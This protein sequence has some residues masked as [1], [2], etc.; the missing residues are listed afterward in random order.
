[1][2]FRRSRRRPELYLHIGQPKSG[3][4]SLQDFLAQERSRLQ[5]QGFLYPRLRHVD[6]DNAQHA[7]SYELREKTVKG[8][9]MTPHDVSRDAGVWEQLTHQVK[10]T[11]CRR[12][13]LS[14]ED[15]YFLDQ[16]SRL[17]RSALAVLADRL[18]PMFDSI[19]VVA[20]LRR[21]D[22]HVESWCNELIK[23]GFNQSTRDIA[24]LADTLPACHSDYRALRKSWVRR[25]GEQAVIFKPFQR[26]RLKN[27]SVVD[28][29]C[30]F[31]GYQPSEMLSGFEDRNPRLTRL[32]FEI[33]RHLN[34]F[35]H[36]L[37][38]HQRAVH[39]IRESAGESRHDPGAGEPYQYFNAPLRD[40]WRSSNQALPMN[41]E[42]PLFERQP[43]QRRD[44]CLW[45]SSDLDD[46]EYAATRARKRDDRCTAAAGALIVA[47]IDV[48]RK[49]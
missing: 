16:A 49:K 8:L 18:R 36:S 7:L 23:F 28:D 29:F 14:S 42:D 10:H 9:R 20:Y 11:D 1:M 45:R 26:D 30:D 4:T 19:T 44:Y 40:L 39:L 43:E 35:E 46:A 2:W 22:Q 13:I 33:V 34:R 21:Q 41:F 12:V 25:F 38:V 31:I 3:T 32:G 47:A 6:N 24:S 37:E 15:F 27:G 5:Q 48:M 17:R